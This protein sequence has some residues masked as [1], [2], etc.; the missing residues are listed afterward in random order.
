MLENI[1][2][3]TFPSYSLDDWREKAERSLR[4]QKI[5]T[6]Q[7]STYE[8]IILKPLYTSMDEN[9]VTQYPGGGD[10]RRG[11]DPLGYVTNEW[12][13]A[14]QISANTPEEL[15]QKLYDVF[16]KGQ[17]AISFQ[18]NKE[19]I[20]YFPYFLTELYKKYPF[21]LNTKRLQREV[22]SAL[23]NLQ[24]ETKDV[25]GYIANDPISLFIVDGA[26][27]EEFLQEWVE[28]VQHANKSFPNLRTILVD[29]TPYHN[30]GAN[31]VQELAVAA[32]TG[33]FYLEQLIDSGM[34]LE[35]ALSKI[36]F[37][38]SIGSNFFM[39]LAKLRAARV[40][41]NRVTELYGAEENDRKMHIAATT[42]Y[43]TKTIHDPH[44]NLLRT[45]NEAFAAVLGGV[46]YL[47]VSPFDELTGSTILSERTARNIQLILKEESHLQKVIDPAGGSWYIE[48]LTNQLAE[49]AWEF[50]KKIDE[51]GGILESLKTNWMQNE[52]AV[53]FD[54]KNQDIQTRKQKIIG[55]NVYAKLDEVLSNQKVQKETADFKGGS[56]ITIEAIPQK[57]L[58]EPFEELRLKAKELEEKY[59]V[60]PTVAILCLGELKQHKPRLDFMKGFFA[61]GG[62]HSLESKPIHSI[63][64]AR[65][66]VTN[67]NSQFITLCGTD[68]LYELI[69]HEI[70]KLLKSENSNLTFYLA[71][72]P[73]KDKQDQWLVEGIEK[74]IHIKSNCYQTVKSILAAMEVTL[75]EKTKA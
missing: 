59:G 66:F 23:E 21:S 49:K 72:L 41:W 26:I 16:E 12:K 30:G 39:E 60:V 3:Q 44:V 69:G 52:I 5:E 2:K 22:L 55:T 10:Y 20:D 70:V 47:N 67:V 37:Q 11:I 14:Q 50:F 15:K 56:L 45:A 4:G 18:I 40:I 8:N 25:T 17:T 29:T 46:Q 32:A 36:I 27:S 65:E 63:E 43:F 28:V 34:E 68:D 24:L 61:A 51:K 57:R 35:N 71:G 75:V 53:V 6:L 19:V 7:S 33:V 38:F 54:K 13:I 1:L 64:Q 31:A 42:S 48:T 74:F 58:A 62:V 9:S 73:E